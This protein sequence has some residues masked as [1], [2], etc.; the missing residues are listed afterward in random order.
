MTPGRELTAR[1]YFEVPEGSGP[2]VLF[3]RRGEGARAYLVEVGA[4]Q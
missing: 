4:G 1:I 2:H 3:V